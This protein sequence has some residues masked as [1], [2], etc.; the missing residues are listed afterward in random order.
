MMNDPIEINAQEVSNYLKSKHVN[1]SDPNLL[2]NASGRFGNAQI[3]IESCPGPITRFGKGFVSYPITWWATH[4]HTAML[5][6]WFGKKQRMVAQMRQNILAVILHEARNN[7][8]KTL[9][10][11]QFYAKHKLSSDKAGFA[12]RILGGVFTTHATTKLPGQKKSPLN[13]KQKAAIGMANFVISSYGAAIYAIAKGARKFEE[14]VTMILVGDYNA[15]LCI[16]MS[17]FKFTP[18]TSIKYNATDHQLI[19]ELLNGVDT[20]NQKHRNHLTPV[21]EFK[22]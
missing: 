3:N 19:F 8:A 13:G 2:I 12:G 4:I 14:I 17:K 16:D 7:K 20:L 11:A 5:K 22:Y 18:S 15:T 9:Q 1:T 10:V 6:G 21:N